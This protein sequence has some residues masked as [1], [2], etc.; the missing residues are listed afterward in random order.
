[1][2]AYSKMAELILFICDA[3]VFVAWARVMATSKLWQISS[4][5]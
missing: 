1:M 2:S 3:V 5:K 4:P